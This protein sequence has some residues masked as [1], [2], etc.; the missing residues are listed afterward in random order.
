MYQPDCVLPERGFW[1]RPDAVH[2]RLAVAP[3]RARGDLRAGAV[4]PHVPHAGR[5]G[6][7]G[8]QHAVRAVAPGSGPRRAR[9]SCG[10][11]SVCGPASCGR[12][13]ST[14][15]T[16]RRRSA[17]TRRAGSDARAACTGSSRTW[18]W[19]PIDALS[20]TSASRCSRTAKLFIGGEFPRSESGRSYEVLAH[21]GRPLARAAQASRKDLRDAVRAARAAQPEWAGQDRVQPGADP[22]PRG[23]AHGGPPGAVRGRAGRRGRRATPREGVDAA[24]DRWV[25]YAG[26]ADKIA[27]GRSGATNPVAGPYFNFTIP[28][29]TGVV[30]IVAPAGPVAARLWSRGSRRR[31][32]RATRSSS[33]RA[34]RSPL[35]AVSL[36]EVLATSDVPGGVVN[37]LTGLTRGA[38][39]VARRAHGRERDRRDG[40]ARRRSWPR[41]NALAAE[42]VKRVVAA[43]R[44]RP[45][46]RRG[47]EP[48]RGHGADGVQDRLAPDGRLR[49]GSGRT[50]RQSRS[51]GTPVRRVSSSDGHVDRGSC[52]SWRPSGARRRSASGRTTGKAARAAFEA[53]LRQRRDGAAHEGLA[54]ALWW[55][56]DTDGAISQ[57]E[58]AYAAYR[59]DSNTRAAAVCALWLVREFEAAYGHDAVSGGWHARAEGLLRE[60]GRRP[61]AGLARALS[62]AERPTAPEEMH[63]YAEAAL[64]VARR[65]EDADLEAAALVRDGYADVASGSVEAGMAKVDEALAAATGA[66]FGAWRRSATSSA[67]GSP[68]ASS[69]RIGSGSSSGARRSKGRS[70]PTT[71]W[72]SSGSATRAAPRCSSPP[73]SGR[74]PTGC[75]TE[76]LQRHAGRQPPSACVHPVGQARRAPH[77]AG[78]ARGG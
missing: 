7:E 54:R 76:G 78:P 58:L 69:R 40:R 14:G 72:P 39:A 47:P 70:P 22:L 73:A 20:P 36:G 66:R 52:R 53:A 74:W 63:R 35:P 45:V 62:R 10:W 29:P 32:C 60:R 64:E 77:R 21:D 57:M 2:R 44:R 34:S 65:L 27:P 12:T 25:W 18:S 19:T 67:S 56:H 15:S 50:H 3:D 42:N 17:A 46:R 41:S 71:T 26:W 28:E 24:I 48:V 31:S 8:E 4:D 13:R 5:G 38:R 75:S 6:R 55:L 23:G 51:L 43:P 49:T 37:V 11:P 30:G 68:P 61:R 1:F 9:G 33:S 59:E 16:R